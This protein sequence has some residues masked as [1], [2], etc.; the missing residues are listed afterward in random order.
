M[1]P[2]PTG[3]VHAQC[4]VP[5]LSHLCKVC[6]ALTAL[7]KEN[8]GYYMAKSTMVKKLI[9][10][11]CTVCVYCFACTGQPLPSASRD[12]LCAMMPSSFTN[13]H[14]SYGAITM[15]QIQFPGSTGKLFQAVAA[16]TPFRFT[17]AF[18]PTPSVWS[19]AVKLL[20]TATQLNTFLQGQESRTGTRQLRNRTRDRFRTR[21]ATDLPAMTMSM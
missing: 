20:N 15:A 8:H 19:L 3:T 1:C 13:P 6:P 7:G 14:Q 16:F 18:Q 12:G 11:V 5:T 4:S 10:V 21:F 2:P 9:S 17:E